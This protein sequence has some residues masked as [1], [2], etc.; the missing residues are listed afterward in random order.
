MPLLLSVISP[1]ASAQEK[2]PRIGLV[3]SGGGARGLAHIGVLKVLEEM[4]IPISCIAGTSMGSLVG[5]IYATGMPLDEMERRVATMQWEDLFTDD[6]P[7]SEKPFLAKRDDYENLFDLELGQRGTRI[8]LPPGST[9]GYKFEFLLRE[10]VAPAGNFAEMDFDDLPIPF[11]AMGTDIEQGKS[12][13]FRDGDLVK[14]MRASM[15]VPGAIAPV[16]IDGTLYV[17]GGLLQNLPV[18]TARDAC[19]DVVIAV[20]VGGGLLP[21]EELD[22]ALGI[23]LQ[24]INVMMEQNVRVSIASLGPGDVLIEPA[25]GNYSSVDF[26]GAMNLIPVGEAAAR[27]QADKL[28]RYS[29][30]E[31]DYRMWRASV[32]ARLPQVPKVRR[33]EVATSGGRVNPEV[34]EQE[35][36]EVPGIDLRR[37]P[38]SDFSLEN[39]N[40]RLEQIYGR[41]DFERMDYRM[42]DRQGLRTVRVEG[43]EKSWGPNYVK[44]GLGFATDADQTRF[45]VNLS[46]RSTWI[47][48]LGAEWRNDLQLGYRDRLASEFYQPVT[49]RAW[50]FIAPRLEF[51]QEPIVYFLDGDRIGDYRVTT[52]RAHLD[53]GMQNKYG[54]IRLG[55]FTGH[56][57]AQED[58]ALV[59]LVSDYSLDQTGYTSRIIIDQIDD[60][61][62]GYNGFL[63]ILDIQGTLER[64][65]SDDQYNRTELFLMGA[66]SIG[67]HSFELSGY[68]GRTLRGELPPYDPFLLG[69][70]LRGSG[71]RMDELLGERVDLLR[72]VY[73]YKLTSLPPPL[74]KGLY[75][76][77]SL[78]ATRGSLDSTLDASEKIH[79]S[80]SLFLAADTFLGPAYLAWGQTLGHDPE[81]TLYFMLGRP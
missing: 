38:E 27:Q 53:L 8:L 54:E 21:R 68:I 48:S 23:S 67:K 32:L 57:N 56:L 11:R 33:V 17:D 26:E 42:V 44:F 14:A 71:Y 81:G 40:T 25:L 2:Q 1:Q 62:F 79:R 6:P 12:K 55:V 72:T 61:S 78:E 76:G 63:G 35:L 19:A 22:S 36:A 34:I 41:G 77:G 49:S 4:R 5:G 18:Q 47:N 69:G 70:F 30:S 75:L 16:D 9:G 29:L 51:Q 43:V 28:R 37:R 45:N 50:F 7:R 13:Q 39:L 3:L 66:K 15:S 58:F 31:S 59:D 60:P 46:H 52:S 20:N 10:M 24:M 65:G 74:G 80:M 64:W 73:S